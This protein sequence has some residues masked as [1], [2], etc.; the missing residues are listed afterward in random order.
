MAR[1]KKVDKIK[2]LMWKPKFIRNIGIVAHIDHG[3][4]TLSDNLLA[5]AGMIS[6]ELAGQQLYLDFDEQEQERGI[7]INAANVSMVHEYEGQDYLINLIDTPGHVDFGGDVTRAMRAVDGV[8]VVVD[9]VE[10]VMPQ[11]ETVLRQALK[12]NVKPVL[13]VNKVD[14]LIKELELTPQQMQE[15]LIKVITEVNKLIKAMR[16]DKYSEWKIDVANGSAAFGSALYNWAVSVPSQ[17]KTGIGFKEVYEHIKEG[18]VKELAKK[19]PLY[20]VVLDMVI[21]HLPSPIEAQKERIAVIW[22]GDINSEVGKAMVN[23]DPKGPV[24]LMIT[25]IVVEPQAGEIAVGRLYSGTI[26]PGMELYIV[27]RKAKNRIQ[28]VGL[29]MGP[30]RV[31]VDEIPAGNIVAVIGLKDAVA[32][33][34]CTTVENLTPFESIKHY[35]EPV[36]T[37]AIEAKNPRDLPKL[38]EVLRKLAKEDPTLHITLNEETGEHL[39]SG[40][41]ELHLE[42]KVEKIRRD[43]KLDVITSPP[44]VV[45]RETVTGTSPVVEGK[46]PNKH[47]RFYIVVEPLPE[48]VIQM[49]K[50]GVVDMKMDKKERRRLLQEAGLTSEEAAG[51]EEYYEGNLFCD[52]TK[53]IQYLN[54]TMELILE[55]FRE[56]MR[57]GPIAREPCM[58][59]KVKLVD[60]KLHEDA[61]HRGP[62]QVIPAVRSAIFA[63]ILQAKP[64]L[65]EPYQK[66]FITV[67]QDM[68]G[69]VTREI[70][71]RRGQIL[72]MKTEG[73]MV[74]IIAKAPVKEMFG[75]A[76]AIR[77]ATSGKAIWST[78]HAGF[79][80]VPQN[81]FQEFVM[82]V[83]KRKGLKLEMPK[84]E[85]F[86]GL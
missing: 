65:L 51:A 42:V 32:G 60:C 12:E 83:R 82:E 8:I 78:E 49:F 33:S 37:M 72:E 36:V 67:P 28:T 27:D 76:G 6:E 31:E 61:V 63:A 20:Q 62:A 48:K 66:I 84:P 11:T 41:G 75:F 55:G 19:S 70:Q 56:A 17:K 79:E 34:T 23:C 2:E 73:D 47:N 7:T 29:Y 43:Y 16:P 74:T 45:F 64:A 22:K 15:R 77:G 57:A 54:E 9:A 53:G 86:V 69:A 39:I 3:K 35:S 1:A 21:R 18:K 13:F 52:V 26:R 85:D 30:R 10:G 25:K 81:L 44:I 4:T 59:I 80:L 24:A 58:G 50:E 40:M 68:M 38:I 5:G 14:R 71:G 46:S